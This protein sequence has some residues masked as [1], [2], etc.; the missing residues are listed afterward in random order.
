[1]T[2][3]E[4]S[5]DVEKVRAE[6]PGIKNRI[7]FNNAG[8]ALQPQRVVDAVISHIRLEAE[9]GG[10]EAEEAN[11]DK[12]E[13]LYP[14][15]AK[16]INCQPEEIAFIENATRAWDMAF[17]SLSLKKGDIIL[18]GYNEY[19]SNYIAFLQRCKKTGAEI[20]LVPNDDSGQ[21]DVDALKSMVD[22]KVRLIAVTHVATNGGLVNPAAAIGEVARKHGILYLLD[23]CQSVGQMTI[24]TKELNCDML[25]AT[26][27]KYLRGPRGTGF[28]YVRTETAKN[29][30]PIFL[31]LHSAQWSSD[32]TF[33]VRDDARKFENWE[34]NFAGKL[35]LATAVDYLIDV[36]VVA[37]QKRVFALAALFR[38]HL[39]A[40]NGVTVGDNG[41][42][43]CGIT[44]FYSDKVEASELVR[45][46]AERG[47]NTTYT[48]AFG[49]RLD[50]VARKLPPMVRA[51]VHY[52]NTEDEILK[53]CAA[54]K[55][56]LESV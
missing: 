16:L 51:S 19:A 53:F 13:Q 20:R 2:V 47:I 44:T 34:Q 25:S 30:E 29:I 11:H 48:T 14:R 1:M 52:Y 28:L 12:I 4:E 43:Q 7:H 32:N 36:G 23:A 41:K 33:E 5:I 38:K 15:V 17:Y 9:I 10:Y 45:L 56:I 50:M 31:D 46:L 27:R 21:L 24:D 26:G 18:T 55:S 22:D 39:A 37:V 3:A 42:V 54:L 49:T 35:G 40:L 8:A 6:T